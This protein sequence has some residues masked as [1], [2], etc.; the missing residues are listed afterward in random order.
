MLIVTPSGL[1]YK[2]I[3]KKIFGHIYKK[4]SQFLRCNYFLKGCSTPHLLLLFLL[5]VDVFNVSQF[6]MMV[7]L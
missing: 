4:I 1:Y 3:F 7:Y 5:L 6:F 2:K